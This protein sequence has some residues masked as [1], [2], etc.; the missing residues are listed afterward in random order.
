[1][2]YFFSPLYTVA[3]RGVRGVFLFWWTFRI[4]CLL[5]FYFSYTPSPPALLYACIVFLDCELNMVLVVF[6]FS[7]GCVLI[8]G[9][10]EGVVF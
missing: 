1:M 4:A 5:F 10:G 7:L 3:L 9:E 6:F 2:S 8:L